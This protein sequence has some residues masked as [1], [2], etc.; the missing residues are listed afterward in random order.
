MMSIGFLAELITAYTVP[1]RET[2]S[3]AETTEQRPPLAG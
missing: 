1:Q 2:Y 3:I